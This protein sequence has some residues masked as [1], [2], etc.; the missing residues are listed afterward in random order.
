SL[1][2]RIGHDATKRLCRDSLGSCAAKQGRNT[3]QGFGERPHCR[4]GIERTALLG[5]CC[6][7]F[8][9]FTTARFS[10]HPSHRHRSQWSR[11]HCGYEAPNSAS[12]LGSKLLIPGWVHPVV[13]SGPGGN[14]LSE[15]NRTLQG[16]VLPYGGLGFVSSFSGSEITSVRLSSFR[17]THALQRLLQ[18]A[19]LLHSD[20]VHPK[21]SGDVVDILTELNDACRRICRGLGNPSRDTAS[22]IGE[23]DVVRWEWSRLNH[24]LLGS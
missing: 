4:I 7:S 9:C 18:G 13:G 10:H 21:L 19:A 6:A 15:L 14:V 24:L 2:G 8:L 5:G 20:C 23:G 16:P 12:N 1:I 3:H 22:Q 17:C 11:S